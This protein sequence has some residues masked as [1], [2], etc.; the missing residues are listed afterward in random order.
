MCVFILHYNFIT[1]YKQKNTSNG[2]VTLPVP[3]SQCSHPLIIW[4]QGH[5]THRQCTYCYCLPIE[6]E[7]YS[8]ASCAV[9][10]CQTKFNVSLSV[11][12]DFVT[13]GNVRANESF[14]V[15]FVCERNLCNAPNYC[16]VQYVE[17]AYDIYMITGLAILIK[18]SIAIC[19]K[20]KAFLS[21]QASSNKI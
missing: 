2:S 8:F 14:F 21:Y 1:G 20:T 5:A 16:G 7:G 12:S 15:Y 13:F 9:N 3:P 10:Q 11:N 19:I 17:M 4:P 6:T 18:C